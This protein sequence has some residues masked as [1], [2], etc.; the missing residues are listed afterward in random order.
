[1]EVG[2]EKINN[3]FLLRRGMRQFPP[4]KISLV[5]FE[6]ILVYLEYILMYLEYILV[7]L[8]YIIVYL[9]Y[10]L[11]YLEYIMVYLEYILMHILSI[12]WC[13]LVYSRYLR[14]VKLGKKATGAARV[15]L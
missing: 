5:Y 3:C 4:G 13:I 9:E 11:V 14:R 8:E 15:S 12:F 1:M 7:Y 6:Y 10:I 2:T